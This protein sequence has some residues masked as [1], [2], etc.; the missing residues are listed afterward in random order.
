MFIIN[1]DMRLLIELTQQQIIYIIIASVVLALIIFL[2]IFIPIRIKNRSKNFKENY[3]KKV[4]SVAFNE[5]YY[6]INKFFFK[7]DESKMGC[8]DHILF[9]NKY[10]YIITDLYYEGNLSGSYDDKSLIFTNQKGKKAYTDN[11]FAKSEQLV[12]RISALTGLDLSILVGI[13]LVNDECKLDIF[14]DSEQFYIV[15]KRKFPGLIKQ[16]ERKN[17][18]VLNESELAKAVMAIN[19]LNKKKKKAS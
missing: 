11:P 10:I 6:L 7:V 5:D 16:M 18:G 1:F 15:Q 8:V 14:S 2:A 4:Y 13:V 17:I 12:Q 3:Y 9:G 19:K